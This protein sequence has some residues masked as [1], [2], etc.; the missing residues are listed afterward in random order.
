MKIAIPLWSSALFVTAA[1]SQLAASAEPAKTVGVG[2]MG[3]SCPECCASCC[4]GVHD[5]FGVYGDCNSGRCRWALRSTLFQW[6]SDSA[7][8]N[9]PDLDEP[10]STDRPDFTE[11]PFTVGCGVS[12]IESGYTYTYNSDDGQSNKSHSLGELLLRRGI[13]ANWLELRVGVSPLQERTVATGTKDTD[14]GM[15]DLYLGAKIGLFSQQ[16]ILPQAALVPQ[17]NVPVGSDAFSSDHFEPGVNL[18]Y[19]WELN[20]FLSTAGS[21][22]GNQRVDGAGQTYLEMTQSWVV[23]AGLSENLGA[24]AEW[25]GIIPSGAQDVSTQHYFNGGFTYLLSKDVQLDVRAGVGLSHAADDY[26]V[27]TGL[28]IR[29]P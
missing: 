26:F 11:S 10:L 28:A 5:G 13:L 2:G 23:G 21:T 16:G 19:G 29:F 1:L 8:A 6:R 22:Q 9:G 25:F 14:A 15:E 7:D 24:Y 20:G 3:Y 27:G 4:C 18:I 17:I 12:Q